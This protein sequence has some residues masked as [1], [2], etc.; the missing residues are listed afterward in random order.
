MP[1]TRFLLRDLPN[2][3]LE[4]TAIIQRLST[5]YIR[6]QDAR[7][8]A[9]QAD[10]EER[11]GLNAAFGHGRRDK[12]PIMF[13]RRIRQ[14]ARRIHRKHLREV[15]AT[16]LSTEDRAILQGC[17]EGAELVALRS[18]HHADEIAAALH[19][20]FPWMEEATTHV[21]HSLRQNMAQGRPGARFAPVLLVGFPGI[22]KS[23]WARRLARL[24]ETPDMIVDATVENASFGLVGSQRG[25]SSA[26]PGR[27][28]G[29]ML[30]QQVA[31]PLVIIDELEKTGEPTSSTG[32]SFSLPQ[33]LLPLLEPLTASRWTCP[34]FRVEFDM[35]FINWVFTSNSLH[36][37][38]APL[39]SRMRVI[40]VPAPSQ[41]QIKMLVLRE[42][43]KRE[44]TPF[45]V[46]TVMAALDQ[47]SEVGHPI[48]LRTV[49]RALDLAADQQDRPTLH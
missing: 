40:H 31:N 46:E 11:I 39:L 32:R 48:N 41:A 16:R 43:V 6:L 21:W 29:Q 7:R 28:L 49:G 30:A 38:S 3:E 42:A 12:L 45:T 19:A 44:L 13:E 4:E 1:T 23:A 20:E 37:L 35:S 33:A 47:A 9:E 34:Y 25:W 22:G 24:L 2:P 15:E 10:P 17:R 26:G 5:F 14:W 36:G 27:L 8:S 18:A